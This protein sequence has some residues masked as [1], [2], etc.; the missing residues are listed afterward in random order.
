MGTVFHSA[1]LPNQ[2]NL[3]EFLK[4]ATQKL[5]I[6]EKEAFTEKFSHQILKD[7]QNPNERFAPNY[8]PAD[9]N[10]VKLNLQNGTLTIYPDGKR[11]LE[12]FAKENY[13]TYVNPYT[14]ATP[15]PIALSSG[16]FCCSRWN[17][18]PALAD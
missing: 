3:S 13:F 12:P 7:L 4:I 2:A 6:A 8:Y 11:V 5:K 15:K 1:D 18:R 17:A 14:P 16:N 9:A 10:G